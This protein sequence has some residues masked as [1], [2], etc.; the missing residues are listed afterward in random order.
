MSE[1]KPCPFCG[2]TGLDFSEEGSTYRWASAS[3]G[4]CGATTG[5]VRKRDGWH[6]DAIAEW[7]TRTPPPPAD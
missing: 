5:E 7:N 6:E 3:C 1:P 4:G 2:H